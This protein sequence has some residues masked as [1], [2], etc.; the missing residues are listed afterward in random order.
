MTP[1]SKWLFVSAVLPLIATASSGAGWRAAEPS[2]VSKSPAG[3]RAERRAYDGA[4][5]VIP[6]RNFGIDCVACHSAEGMEV[7]DVGFAPPS[8]H[9]L[10]P[11]MSAISRCRQ[12]HVFVTTEAVF[13]DNDFEGLRQD[14]RHGARLHPS[15]PPVIPHKTFMRE[16]CLAC[17]AGPAAREEIRTSHPEG[18]RCRQCHVPVIT[19]ERFAR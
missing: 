14:L 2:E 11:G 17:H 10:T 4:P 9:E 16:N 1:G 8:P 5:P 3:V 18:L 13:R 12:C 15:A 7:D 6:H 19:L